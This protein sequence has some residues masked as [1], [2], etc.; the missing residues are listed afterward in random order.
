MP[1]I[2][3]LNGFWSSSPCGL[4]VRVGPIA[5]DDMR[6]RMLSQPCSQR[7]CLPVG[8]KVDDFARFEIAKDGS[9]AM[10]FLPRPIVDAENAWSRHDTRL[11]AAPH[12]SKQC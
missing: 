1:A 2:G 6:S 5:T 4:G 12:L 7:L 8:K 10:T 3:D 9:I 11:N